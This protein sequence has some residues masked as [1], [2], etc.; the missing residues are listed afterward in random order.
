LTYCIC[1][2]RKVILRPIIDEIQV[3]RNTIWCL[4]CCTAKVLTH[5]PPHYASSYSE[6]TLVK[7]L[8]VGVMAGGLLGGVSLYVISVMSRII[9]SG[10]KPLDKRLCEPQIRYEHHRLK[11][12]FFITRNNSIPVVH[13]AMS[14]PESQIFTHS[15]RDNFYFISVDCCCVIL[16]KTSEIF[17]LRTR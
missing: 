12:Y 15:E 16:N 10:N 5:P 13:K 2:S 17:L 11:Y 7:N 14:F 9:I 1:Y 4:L 3:L 8:I 6:T